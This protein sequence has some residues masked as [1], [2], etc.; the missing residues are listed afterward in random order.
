MVW[1]SC[2]LLKRGV[3]VTLSLDSLM[4]L[5][6]LVKGSTSRL[7]FLKRLELRIFL[8]VDTVTALEYLHVLELPGGFLG[9]VGRIV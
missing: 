3:T 9:R 8:A 7:T 6:F 2:F 1:S 5:M 4:L